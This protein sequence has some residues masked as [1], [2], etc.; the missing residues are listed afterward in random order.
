MQSHEEIT[1]IIS[2][3]LENDLPSYDSGKPTPEDLSLHSHE[4]EL[5]T[6][7]MGAWHGLILPNAE[8]VSVGAPNCQR[9]ETLPRPMTDAGRLILRFPHT[10]TLGKVLKYLVECNWKHR[11]QGGL[12]E[13]TVGAGELPNLIAPLVEIMSGPE[14]R[15]LRAVYHF[16]DDLPQT[17][18]FF[19]V[20]SFPHFVNEARAAWLIEVLRAQS[21]YSVFQPIVRVPQSGAAPEIFGYECLMRGLHNGQ[22]VAPDTMIKMAR[23]ADLIF[24]LDLA[25]RRTALIGA[26][27]HGIKEKVFI[28]LAQLDLRSLA[29]S[30]FDREHGG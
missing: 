14:Q 27:K 9:C 19:E 8:D 25:G 13:I 10:F 20:E 30:A 11:H 12:V 3:Q 28:N 7:L 23:G 6:Q 15:D 5:A 29:L 2:A 21:I 4:A 1:P 18:D 22:T 16:G 17:S 26:G 24:Q